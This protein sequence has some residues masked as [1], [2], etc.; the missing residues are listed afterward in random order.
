MNLYI[1]VTQ[2]LL[3]S[4]WQYLSVQI[5][6]NKN[7]SQTCECF[8]AVSDRILKL[9][10]ENRVQILA[11]FLFP[12]IMAL[13]QLWL[14]SRKGSETGDDRGIS[15]GLASLSLAA[16]PPPPALPIYCHCHH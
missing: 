12:I 2:K 7:S 6:Q 9:S 3:F 13:N 14:L 4:R 1:S 8:C 11:P 16:T 5:S 15:F 10:S